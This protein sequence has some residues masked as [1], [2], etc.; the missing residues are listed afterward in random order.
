MGAPTDEAN[1]K[2]VV[3]SAGF[4]APC[5]SDLRFRSLTGGLSRSHPDATW[6]LPGVYPLRLTPG[7]RRAFTLSGGPGEGLPAK[8]L[9]TTEDGE[10]KRPKSAMMT[11]RRGQHGNP[12]EI[13]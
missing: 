13:R 11:I 9:C 5:G 12:P 3:H 1:G 2:T 4:P 6:A 8:P 7:R 10:V